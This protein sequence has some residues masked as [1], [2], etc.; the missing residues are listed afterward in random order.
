MSHFPRV[1]L[2]AALAIAFLFVSCHKNDDTG[3]ASGSW[4][5]DDMVFHQKVSRWDKYE[6]GRGGVDSVYTFTVGADTGYDTAISFTFTQKPVADK[7]YKMVYFPAKEDEVL[8][9]TFRPSSRPT[10]SRDETGGQV[11]ARFRDGRMT[12]TGNDV[13]LRNYTFVVDYNSHCTFNVTD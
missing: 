4:L 8:V 10:S 2:L 7:N 9:E 6:N 3:I 12:L 5:L 11:S 1:R 13:L